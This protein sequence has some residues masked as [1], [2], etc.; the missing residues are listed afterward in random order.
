MTM[1]YHEEKESALVKTVK[2]SLL[3]SAGII[4]GFLAS[5]IFLVTHVQAGNSMEPN[6]PP[7]SRA[8][9]VKHVTPRKGDMVLMKSPV[10]E[11][12]VLLTRVVAS[13]GD[14]VEIRNKTVYVNSRKL[15]KNWKTVMNDPRIFPMRFS[16]R[17]NMPALRVKRNEF[18][19]MGD[20]FDTGF[21]SRN[22]GLVSGD[23]IIGR[24][25]RVTGQ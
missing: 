21:D 24:V 7:G 6:A 2:I 16:Y 22:F 15:K 19:V 12:T 23:R 11:G 14:T 25:F 8:F 3:V 9:V 18:F 10:K 5:R 17:D 4:F 1:Y 20:N 13:E